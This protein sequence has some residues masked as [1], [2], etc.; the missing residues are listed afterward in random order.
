MFTNIHWCRILNSP[1][2]KQANHALNSFAGFNIVKINED[3]E[4]GGCPVDLSQEVDGLYLTQIGHY[5][6]TRRFSKLT[7]VL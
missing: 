3:S 4:N 5:L 7:S 2:A 1:G 6:F